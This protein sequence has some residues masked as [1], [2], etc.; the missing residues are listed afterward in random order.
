LIEPLTHAFEPNDPTDCERG[1][2]LLAAGQVGCLVLAGGQG[3]RL[4][5]PGPKGTYPLTRFQ[6][7]TLFQ[8]LCEKTRAAS[9]EI[10]APLPLAIMTSPLNHKETESY[11]KKQGRFGLDVDQIVLFEQEMQPFIGGPGSGPTGNGD[12]LKLLVRAGIWQGRSLVQ[13]VPIDNPLANPFDA[14][15]CGFHDRQGADVTMKVIERKGNEKVGV[16]GT[17]HGKIKVI[18]YFELPE[19]STGWKFAHITLFCFSMEFAKQVKDVQLPW[20][21]A[22]KKGVTKRETFI[23]DLLDYAKE[24]RVIVYPRSE[25]YAPLKNAE[26]ENSPET[27]R[28]ALLIADQRQYKKVTGVDVAKAVFELDPR[29]YFPSDALIKKWRGRPLPSQ[30]YVEA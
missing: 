8:L 13:V 28:A 17:E 10:G 11:L 21:H 19:E 30:P 24:P 18:E 20:H 16:V 12:A 6:K 26:G 9:E 7:K 25:T 5:W 3:T 27:V 29:F 22:Q 23:F 15:L 4:N 14:T 2:Q 1:R